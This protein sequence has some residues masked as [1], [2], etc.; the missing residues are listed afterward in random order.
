[1]HDEV[2]GK[3]NCGFEDR[4]S[5]S[6]KNIAWPVRTYLVQ[7]EEPAAAR[8]I[9]GAALQ[10]EI[11]YCRAPD[12]V[13]LAWAK[14][15]TGPPI[16]KAANWLNHLEYDWE[17]PVWRAFLERLARGNTLI[18]YDARGNGLSH[19]DVPDVSLNAWVSDLKAV[20]DDA[21]PLCPARRLAG[22]C[23]LDC[24]RGA[25]SRAGVAPHLV[26][27]VRAWRLQTLA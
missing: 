24:L 23:G 19:W 26:W 13:R 21:R 16:V 22:L 1:M 3:L 6:V 20:V 4:G 11:E 17:S 15:G 8:S 25:L 5:R 9:R 18:R 12:G 7:R 10:Q 2:E 14:V 27:R